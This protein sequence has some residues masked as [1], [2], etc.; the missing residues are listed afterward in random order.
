LSTYPEAASTRRGVGRLAIHYSVFYENPMLELIEELLKAFPLG[1]SI[2]DVYGRLPLHYV[3]D[4]PNP[5]I[6]IVKCLLSR[7][8]EGARTRDSY[9]RLPLTVALEHSNVSL[10]VV[11]LLY[12][13]YPNAIME[14]GPQGKLPLHTILDASPK[15]SLECVRFLIQ[16][17][18]TSIILPRDETKSGT[19]AFEKCSNQPEIM[20]ELLLINPTLNIQKFYDLNWKARSLIVMICVIYCKGNKCYPNG[21]EFQVSSSLINRRKSL[22]LLQ[23]IEESYNCTKCSDITYSTSLIDLVPSIPPSP[24]PFKCLFCKNINCD[25]PLLVS[26]PRGRFYITMKSKDTRDKFRYNDENSDEEDLLLSP[27]KLKTTIQSTFD[28]RLLLCM[29]R[30]HNDIW[31]IVIG[32]L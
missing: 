3:V 5:C 24:S 22:G 26:S 4:R 28:I 17:Y 12:D 7:Y 15:P 23:G 11:K 10:T 19:S 9:S 29:Y 32:F 16:K 25:I 13:A 18:P 8:P 2:C 31:R 21:E 14:R 20:R 27:S 30:M 1:A 6:P